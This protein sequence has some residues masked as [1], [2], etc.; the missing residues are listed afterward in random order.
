MAVIV[1][2]PAFTLV[3]VFIGYIGLGVDEEPLCRYQIGLAAFTGIMSTAW[4]IDS[5]AQFF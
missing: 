1:T 2:P 3:F 4:G 5:W